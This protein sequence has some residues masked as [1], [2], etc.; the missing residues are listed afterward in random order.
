[1]SHNIL[2][3]IEDNL[4]EVFDKYH[5]IKTSDETE[6]LDNIDYLN[7]YLV[8]RI[9]IEIWQDD[10]DSNLLYDIFHSII[11]IKPKVE[12][13][14]GKEIS[15]SCEDN[16]GNLIKLP[17]RHIDTFNRFGIKHRGF[18]HISL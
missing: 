8:D 12:K 3:D 11:E 7:Y 16:S 4:Q 18:I 9:T 6:D 10:D 5:I 15:V 2:E 17:L 1:M 13:R 14:I